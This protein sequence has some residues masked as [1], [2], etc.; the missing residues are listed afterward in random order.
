MKI[1]DRVY[2]ICDKCGNNINLLQNEVWGCDN[3]GKEFDESHC[4]LNA[5]I[6]YKQKEEDTLEFCS[7]KCAIEKLKTI[8]TDNFIDL[9]YLAF[10]DLE[11]FY[12]DG[13]L[14]K[15]FFELLK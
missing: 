1:K 14:A 4:R 8:K 7:W 13:S 10:D 15:D 3:C 9:P 11:G 6:F 12:Q 2:E 5:T